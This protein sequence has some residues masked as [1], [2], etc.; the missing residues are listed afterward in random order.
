MTRRFVFTAVILLLAGNI[1]AFAQ[2][3]YEPYFPFEEQPDGRIYLPSPA[4]TSH[5]FFADDFMRWIWGKSIRDSERGERASRESNYGV[6]AMT[7]IFGEALSLEITPEKTPALY[8]YLSRV[9][10][11]VRKSS[12]LT[13]RK[14]MRV[15][16]FARMNEQTW[17]KYDDDGLRT[18]GS[19]PSGHTSNG[20]GCCL[21]LAEM[22]PELQDTIIRRGYEYG[23]SRVIVGAHWQS[24][25]DAAMLCC[26][27]SY[28]HL[29][30]NPEFYEDRDA[31]RAEVLRL[32][33]DLREIKNVGMPDGKKIFPPYPDTAS[34]RY[35][36]EMVRYWESKAER[37]TFRATQARSDIRCT[38]ADAY[39]RSFQH[40]MDIDISYSETPAIAKLITEG[41]QAIL[42]NAQAFGSGSFRKRPF[43]Q[44]GE[45]SLVPEDDEVLAQ[46]T[47]YPSFN[48]AVGWGLAMLL[49][50]IA[51]ACQDHILLRGLE[52]G[53]SCEIAGTNYHSDVLDGRLIAIAT[54]V[55]LNADPEFTKLVNAARE[56]YKAKVAE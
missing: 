43:Y 41:R 11:T 39:M 23:E 18:N 54:V 6:A 3:K 48:S 12:R 24:D 20:W 5:L 51:P 50:E 36:G 17:G 21:G 2:E 34:M 13:K 1:S 8:K 53:R 15:R 16:P 44:L 9:S 55:R 19:Y 29:H 33:K 10:E 42:D 35:Y 56:E 37:N 27:A 14:Y 49:V 38:S 7:E 22:L 40:C 52:F 46:T 4:D 32:R 45:N 47:S 30:N 26:A 28:A 25:V 31:A